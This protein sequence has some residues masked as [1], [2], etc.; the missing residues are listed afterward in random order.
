MWL[1]APKFFYKFCFRSWYPKGTWQVPIEYQRKNWK[2]W[3]KKI[4]VPDYFTLG[5]GLSLNNLENNKKN[6]SFVENMKLSE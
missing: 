3:K 1:K 6:Q 5:P 2:K 4:R